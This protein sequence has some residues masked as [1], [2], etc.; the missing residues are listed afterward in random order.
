MEHRLVYWDDLSKYKPGN[1]ITRI[2]EDYSKWKGKMRFIVALNR[3][4]GVKDELGACKEVMEHGA[5][6]VLLDDG[7]AAM[8][9]IAETYGPEAGAE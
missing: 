1:Y 5:Y 2:G 9:Y 7:L 8:K 3:S 4:L 6:M